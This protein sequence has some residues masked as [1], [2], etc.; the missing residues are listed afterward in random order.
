MNLYVSILKTAVDSWDK[1]GKGVNRQDLKVY[2][3]DSIKLYIETMISTE[4]I[5]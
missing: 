4:N 3:S 5:T 2:F 1:S